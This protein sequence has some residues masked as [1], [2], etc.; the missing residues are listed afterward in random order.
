MN[1]IRMAAARPYLIAAS[2]GAALVSSVAGAEEF[3][4]RG[5]HVHGKVTVNL[6]VD[7]DKFAA[8]L[9]AP[10]MNVV[11]FERAPKDA[12]EK[13]IVADAEA[14]LKSGRSAFAV[15]AAAG[16]KLATVD[17]KS[18]DL[19]AH[20]HHDHDH[21]HDHK[22]DDAKKDHEEHTDYTAR[23]TYQCANVAAITAVELLLLKRLPGT[24]EATV[25][26]VTPAKQT[27]VTATPGIPRVSL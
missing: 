26:I 5:T 19:A 8:E 1:S 23:M 7:G 11:G 4:Q 17:L 6:V 14:W 2:I 24:E 22:H 10:A 12:T 13:K 21:D 9:V 15:P 3:E 18:P 20:D 16:C 25:N 27:S